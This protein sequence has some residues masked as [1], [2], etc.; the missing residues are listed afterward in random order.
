[1]I[2]FPWW[3]LAEKVQE[4]ATLRPAGYAAIRVCLQN[5]GRLSARKRTHSVDFLSDDEVARME[6]AV[7]SGYGGNSRAGE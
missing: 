4:Q 7:R 3:T 2:V 5:N 6:E 1:M